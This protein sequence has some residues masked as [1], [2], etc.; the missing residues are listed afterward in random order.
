MKY[1][2]EVI[3]W[4]NTDYKDAKFYKNTLKSINRLNGYVTGLKHQRM[5]K[6]LIR[7]N[8]FNYV[9][10]AAFN[11][12]SGLEN[13]ISQGKQYLN[14]LKNKYSDNAKPSTDD[15]MRELLENQLF[16]SKIQAMNDTELSQYIDDAKNS[17]LTDYQLNRLAYYAK[18]NDDLS[19]KVRG[20]QDTKHGAYKKDPDYQK[21]I[22]K[23]S[24]ARQ[25]LIYSN[26]SQKSKH[27][28][29]NS[30]YTTDAL[31]KGKVNLTSIDM[32]TVLTPD[33]SVIN[34]GQQVHDAIGDYSLKD[35]SQ[36]AGKAFKVVEPLDPTTDVVEPES[37]IQE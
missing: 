7:L 30:R 5:D 11:Y 20:Y 3:N 18:G 33:K 14:Y 15:M 6:G 31:F 32:P 28:M 17:N 26:T 37:T 22:Q 23:I 13:Y 8:A 25:A 36:L 27:S 9:K 4:N 35:P 24:F 21:A 29:I 34:L 2:E 10:Q 12:R 1:S 19:A 16:D